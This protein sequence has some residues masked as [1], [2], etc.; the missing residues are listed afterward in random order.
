MENAWITKKNVEI[1]INAYDCKQRCKLD[2]LD[3]DRTIVY[4]SR[5]SIKVK[6]SFKLL[7]LSFHFDYTQKSLR[8]TVLTTV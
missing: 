2:M 3:S 7:G 6:T 8:E 1:K 5:K 4:I